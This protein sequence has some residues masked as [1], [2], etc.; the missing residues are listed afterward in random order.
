MHVPIAPQQSEKEG[1]LFQPWCSHVLPTQLCP[2]G[3]PSVSQC[4][5]NIGHKRFGTHWQWLQGHLLWP[6][7]PISQLGPFQTLS[8]YHHLQNLWCQRNQQPNFFFQLLGKHSCIHWRPPQHQGPGHTLAL[9]CAF[10]V[11]TMAYGF[12]PLGCLCC[13][14]LWY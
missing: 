9:T 14:L 4:L 2:L 3:Y 7:P 1:L 6:F 11:K 8:W 13:L 10:V 5:H 12:L